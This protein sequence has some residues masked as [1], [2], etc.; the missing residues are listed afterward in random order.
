M[1]PPEWS[2]YRDRV[3][4]L[5][6]RQLT[7]YKGHS[8]HTYFTNSGWYDGGKRLIFGSDRANET[9]LFSVD[10]TTGAIT[11]VTHF[12]RVPGEDMVN[13]LQDVCVNPNR[14]EAYFWLKRDL[15]ALDLH[16]GAHRIIYHAAEGLLHHSNSCTADGQFICTCLAEDLSDRI[17]M[18]LSHG[19]IGFEE[20]FT[21][22]PHCQILRVAVD[23]SRSDI[24]HEE[25]CWI[26]HVNPSP[27]HPQ[28]LSFC[29]E[30]PWNLVD[31]RIWGFDLNTGR[32]WK[33]RPTEKGDALGHEYWLADGESLGYHGCVGGKNLFGF[34]RYD[35]TGHEEF[36]M[37]HGSDHYFSNDR[38]LII[39]DGPGG[40]D[41]VVL[42][43]RK[44]G[45]IGAPRTL[46]QHR[47]SR[48]VQITHVHPRLTA[49]SR[50]VLFTSDRSGYGNLYLVDIPEDVESLP[51][52]NFK[53]SGT[54]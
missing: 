20:Y 8:Y 23:G 37:D 7:N 42:F 49:D 41:Q 28:L 34:V 19:F 18:D 29:H 3:S 6:V 11:Q 27:T 47:S 15:I 17:E 24:M 51:V 26:G 50:Q 21:A 33:I 54:T 1:I 16:S 9:N 2:E 36:P 44:D 10:L 53:V 48:H 45:A 13:A 5:T 40:V 12:P 38:N 30:G 4:G 32:A 43:R 22:R 52:L 39:S 14:N 35:N 25:D 46:C 31:Q